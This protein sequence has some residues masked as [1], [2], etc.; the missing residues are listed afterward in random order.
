MLYPEDKIKKINEI[1]LA[2]KPSYK[3]P[4]NIYEEIIKDA[5]MDNL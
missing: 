3:N 2:T 4:K 5:D 1:I